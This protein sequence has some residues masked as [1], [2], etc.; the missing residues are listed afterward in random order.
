MFYANDGC[1]VGKRLWVRGRGN[2]DY[3]SK[4]RDFSGHKCFKKKEWA[5]GSDWDGFYVVVEDGEWGV[6]E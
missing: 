5:K 1:V 3:E 4:L 6:E 2:Q